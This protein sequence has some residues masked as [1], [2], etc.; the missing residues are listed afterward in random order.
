MTRSAVVLRLLDGSSHASV[1]VAL[2][3][4]IALCNNTRR[5]SLSLQDALLSTTLGT[6]T[7]PLSSLTNLLF[8]TSPVVWGLPHPPFQGQE[9][10]RGSETIISIKHATTTTSTTYPPG[11]PFP[12]RTPIPPHRPAVE[13][14]VLDKRRRDLHAVHARPLHW[15]IL[16][17]REVGPHAAPH[18]HGRVVHGGH[19]RVEEADHVVA[20]AAVGEGGLVGDVL[21]DVEG[22]R[23]RGRRCRRG[24]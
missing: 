3:V 24:W 4:C 11:V 8:T 6:R 2:P 5:V 20:R 14:V 12:S 19:A 9:R 10:R 1:V 21:E 13:V 23:R 22:V 18:K 17:R 16:E 15:T 7:R